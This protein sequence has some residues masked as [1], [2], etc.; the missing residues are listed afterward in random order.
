M[1]LLFELKEAK[2]KCRRRGCLSAISVNMYGAWRTEPAD[3]KNVRNA[4]LDPFAVFRIRKILVD[5]VEKVAGDNVV[6]AA[7]DCE[8]NTFRTQVSLRFSTI[9]RR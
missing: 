5:E 2:S 1:E 6:A 9:K 3:L 4:K 8:L 7:R